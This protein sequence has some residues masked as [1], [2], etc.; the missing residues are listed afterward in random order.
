M[1]IAL[2]Q[3]EQTE[4]VVSLCLAGNKGLE[5]VRPNLERNENASLTNPVPKK[6]LSGLCCCLG[7][8]TL[9]RLLSRS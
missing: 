2:T 5:K 4:E 7:I 8:C 1:H 9:N 6:D 3:V